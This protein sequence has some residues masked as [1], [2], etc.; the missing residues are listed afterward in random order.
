MVWGSAPRCYNTCSSVSEIR[1]LRTVIV[2]FFFVPL[3]F[4]QILVGPVAAQS[5]QGNL[6]YVSDF[7][8]INIKDQLEK[9][10]TVVGVVRSDDPVRIIEE[11]ENYYKIE[12]EDKKQGWI[13]KQYL[14]T[15]I[16]DSLIVKQLKQ[17]IADLKKQPAVAAAPPSQSETAVEDKSA[18]S[19]PDLQ[20]KLSEADKQ[21]RQLTEE[22]ER[23]LSSPP[24]ST[25]EAAAQLQ[26]Q[27]LDMTRQLE[28]TSQ[29]YNL[30]VAEYE[31]RG[32]E[33]AQL[34]NSIA[35]QDDTTRFFWF[36]AG[37]AVFF[38][39]LLAG[40]SASRKK[41]KLMY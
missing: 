12:T 37:A 3:I 29:R 19:C 31:K 39:G 35:K 32:K 26:E 36:G 28:Q 17:E 8:V 13:A 9:P 21:I 38:L 27:N 6:R 14:K 30:L 25:S 22:K 16:P 18:E 4:A 40:K 24:G 23:R 33:I 10:F 34:H 20:Q 41:N 15:E 5:E 2:N 1:M 11:Q 7:L